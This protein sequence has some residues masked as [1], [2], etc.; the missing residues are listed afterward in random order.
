M[1]A[2]HSVL[3][4]WTTLQ[5]S[6]KGLCHIEH[7]DNMLHAEGFIFIKSES[8]SSTDSILDLSAIKITSGETRIILFGESSDFDGFFGVLNIFSEVSDLLEER[9]PHALFGFASQFSVSQRNMDP[10]LESWVEGL[11]AV[12]S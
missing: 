3:I 4:T 1:V 11:D 2:P 10:G 7:L 12:G 8:L 5:I 6:L 9:L